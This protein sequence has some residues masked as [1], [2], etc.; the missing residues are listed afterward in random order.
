VEGDAI[1]ITDDDKLT[2]LAAAWAKISG[3]CHR[4]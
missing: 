2:R 3:T 4:F 1:Q